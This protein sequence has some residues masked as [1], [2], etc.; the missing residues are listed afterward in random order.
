MQIICCCLWSW[1]EWTMRT[2]LKVQKN[3]GLCLCLKFNRKSSRKRSYLADIN[4]WTSYTEQVFVA[5]Q[6]VLI[7]VLSHGNDMQAFVICPCQKWLSLVSFFYIKSSC[8]VLLI[9]RKMDKNRIREFETALVSFNRIIH[10]LVFYRC[11]YLPIFLDI[12]LK[13]YILYMSS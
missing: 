4:R 2:H 10:S 12:F 3:Y 7:Q 9:L 6:H 5:R 1:C 13:E 11:F 8:Y